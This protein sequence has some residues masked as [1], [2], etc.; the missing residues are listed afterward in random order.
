MEFLTAQEASAKR[1]LSFSPSFSLGLGRSETWLIVSA[2]Y[3]E[4]LKSSGKPLKRF[5]DSMRAHPPS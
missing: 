5:Q 3:I 4:I 2:V 1:N